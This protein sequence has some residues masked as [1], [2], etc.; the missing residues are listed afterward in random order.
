[1]AAEPENTIL[2]DLRDGVAELRTEVAELR[3]NFSWLRW[4]VVALVGVLLLPKIG[5]PDPVRQAQKV[6]TKAAQEA[7]APVR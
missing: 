3:V 1:M 6:A 7:P 5:G 4:L 2:E